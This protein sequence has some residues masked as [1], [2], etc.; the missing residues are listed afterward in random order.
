MTHSQGSP[1][2]LDIIRPLGATL[3]GWSLI[4][5]DHGTNFASLGS[6]W[7]QDDV[8]LIPVCLH[9]MRSAHQFAVAICVIFSNS[10]YAPSSIHKYH[11]NVGNDILIMFILFD[12]TPGRI[13]RERIPK[14]E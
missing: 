5:G 12:L 4:A 1:F 3:A 7:P 9:V 11:R 10:A 14:L 8:A 13:P 2:A 6:L